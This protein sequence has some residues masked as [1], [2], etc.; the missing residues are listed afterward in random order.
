M[1]TIGLPQKQDGQY[2]KE[3]EHSSGKRYCGQ[4][5][6]GLTSQS[7][8]KYGGEKEFPTIPKHTT[9]SVIHGGGGVMA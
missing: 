1:Q 6:Q 4:M 8:G 3:Q 7:G 9:S 5:K 2:L